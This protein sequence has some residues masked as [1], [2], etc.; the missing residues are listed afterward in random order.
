[1]PTRPATGGRGR[2]HRYAGAGVA[3]AA[4]I[5]AVELAAGGGSDDTTVERHRGRRSHLK[6][7]AVG[8]D[9]PWPTSPFAKVPLKNTNRVV[10]GAPWSLPVSAGAVP[11]TDG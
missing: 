9:H 10:V 8:P 6:G 7:F 4:V 1:M 11:T 3:L 5:V 2:R